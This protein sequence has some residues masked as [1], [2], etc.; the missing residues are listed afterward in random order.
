MAYLIN[1]GVRPDYHFGDADDVIGYGHELCNRGFQGRWPWTDHRRVKAGF[2]TSN[3][4][5]TSYLLSPAVNELCP[6][7]TWQLPATGSPLRQ[8][9]AFTI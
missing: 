8:R 3:E 6:A 4:F 9:A 1:V 5:R 2:A 7:V